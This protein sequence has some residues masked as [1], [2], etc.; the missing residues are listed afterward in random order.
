MTTTAQDPARALPPAVIFDMDGT[1]VD[2]SGIR[3][4]ILADLT[5]RDFDSFHRASLFCPPHQEVLDAMAA[6]RA[7]GNTII[8]VTA[9]R[10]RYENITRAW[11]RKHDA[12]PDAFVMR[13]NSDDR[14]DVDVKRDILAGIRRHYEVVAAWDDNP[15]VI[16]L[17]RSE[18]IPVTLVPGWD[19]PVLLPD[20]RTVANWAAGA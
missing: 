2:V 14:P 7:S 17:W 11:L 9:R 1:L 3:H 6:Q 8:V 19:D 20:G 15:A 10:Y 18:N 12:I 4:Y 13:S 16:A 5:R